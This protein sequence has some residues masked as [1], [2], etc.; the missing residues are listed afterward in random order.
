LVVRAGFSGGPD[1][2]KTLEA[3]GQRGAKA[4][5]GRCIL[6]AGSSLYRMVG[7]LPDVPAAGGWKGCLFEY[8]YSLSARAGFLPTTVSSG[9]DKIIFAI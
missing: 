8:R 1:P 5:R 6:A 7:R 9:S 3:T 4:K 2:E